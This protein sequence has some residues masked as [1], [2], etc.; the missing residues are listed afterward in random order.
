MA[1]SPCGAT[2]V[3]ALL[4]TAHAMVGLRPAAM[5]GHGPVAPAASTF[6]SSSSL[7]DEVHDTLVDLA[8]NGGVTLGGDICGGNICWQ[9][10]GWL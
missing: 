5:A 10:F 9:H 6:S 8:A 4:A 1:F 3:V 7:V 2:L